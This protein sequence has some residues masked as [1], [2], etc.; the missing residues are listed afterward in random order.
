MA[1]RTTA[2]TEHGILRWGELLRL[3][4]CMH[5]WRRVFFYLQGYGLLC[6]GMVVLGVYL[7]LVSEGRLVRVD[8]G[9][10]VALAGVFGVAILVGWLGSQL[11]GEKPGETTQIEGEQ[12]DDVQGGV[13]S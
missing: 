3:R 2:G 5:G 9:R 10:A 1:N 13:E 12:S 7:N 6:L 11:V 4:V 8:P